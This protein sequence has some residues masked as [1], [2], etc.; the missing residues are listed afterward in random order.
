M[1]VY[2]FFIANNEQ[3]SSRVS[4]RVLWNETFTFSSNPFL[5]T[6]IDNDTKIILQMIKDTH[7]S[8]ISPKSGF[9]DFTV[10]SLPSTV[11]P[12]IDTF[13]NYI[14]CKKFLRF[15]GFIEPNIKNEF[16]KC[17]ILNSVV[18]LEFLV[19]ILLEVLPLEM[20]EYIHKMTGNIEL[21][22]M[23]NDYQGNYYI[24]NPSF[25]VPRKQLRQLLLK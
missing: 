17:L 11:K 16:G 24:S 6:S 3:T 4:P 13:T 22:M 15:S 19:N 9:V 8:L 2:R 12:N 21:E 25:V 5:T 14:D 1:T 20:I 18:S 23:V 7:F 10:F